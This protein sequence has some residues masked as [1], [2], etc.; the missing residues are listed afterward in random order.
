M[1]DDRLVLASAKNNNAPVW[2]SRVNQAAWDLYLGDLL[3]DKIPIYAAPGR[4]TDLAGLP[5]AITYVGDLDPFLGGTCLYA[6]RLERAGIPV[7]CKVFDGCYHVATMA[8]TKWPR[9]PTLRKWPTTFYAPNSSRP[10]PSTGRKTR[11]RKPSVC[12]HQA[13]RLHYV[14]W[15]LSS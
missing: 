6:K 4:A 8:L 1:L 3:L 14:I 7:A 2:N 11:K 10:R 15:A 9:T 13:P 12:K 5:P